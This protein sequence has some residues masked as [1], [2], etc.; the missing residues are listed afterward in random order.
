MKNKELKDE[1]FFAYT[2]EELIGIY[3]KGKIIDA[4]S[5]CNYIGASDET[6]IAVVKLAN[7]LNKMLGSVLSKKD[8]PLVTSFKW[9]ACAI[10]ERRGCLTE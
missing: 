1:I 4:E 5:L 6:I 8:M 9:I 10:A 3:L 7:Y 2:T